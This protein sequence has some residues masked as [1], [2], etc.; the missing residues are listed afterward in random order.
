MKDKIKE[1]LAKRYGEREE[2]Q[3][4]NEEVA[5]EIY[6]SLLPQVDE[7]GLVNIY[8]LWDEYEKND[9]MQNE[10]FAEYCIKAQHLAD[11]IRHQKE[12]AEIIG[13]VNINVPFRSDELM[14]KWQ[15]YCANCLGVEDKAGTVAMAIINLKKKVLGEGSNK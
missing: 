3:E 11:E 12:K 14:A 9:P 13:W 15:T 7:E 1:I 8:K 6:L 2:Y 5:E 10:D 4:Y